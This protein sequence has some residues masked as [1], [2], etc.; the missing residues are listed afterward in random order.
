MDE[1]TT[2]EAAELLNVHPSH[3]RWYF[4]KGL[5]PGRRLGK[6]MLLF[7]RDALESFEKPK[8]TGRPPKNSAATKVGPKDKSAPK[9]HKAP[10]ARRKKKGK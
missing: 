1:L 6:H 7:C 4:K 8:K 3:V 2:E 5:L 9:S 10:K